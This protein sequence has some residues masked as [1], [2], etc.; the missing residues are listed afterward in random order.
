MK[1]G[2]GNNPRMCGIYWFLLG[3]SCVFGTRTSLWPIACDSTLP[4]V[5]EP[6]VCSP[7]LCAHCCAPIVMCPPLYVRYG[8]PITLRLPLLPP[9]EPTAAELEPGRQAIVCPPLCAHYCALS[10]PL[11]PTHRNP[12]PLSWSPAC[13]PLWCLRRRSQGRRTSTRGGSVGALHPCR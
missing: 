6:I 9:Q 3:S 7:L 1:R 13:R 2:E 5:R 11:P 10:P 4:T 8:M 12:L